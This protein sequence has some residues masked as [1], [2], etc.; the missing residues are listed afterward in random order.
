MIIK[1][2]KCLPCDRYFDFHETIIIKVP[3][4]ACFWECC[5]N[6]YPDDTV[7]PGNEWWLCEE[8]FPWMKITNE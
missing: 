6:K 3:E 7:Y 4:W 1:P 5:W 2:E 8:F